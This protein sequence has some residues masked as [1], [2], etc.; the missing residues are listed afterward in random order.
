M[1]RIW[2]QA[3]YGP[4]GL[5][6]C[7]DRSLQAVKVVAGDWDE[8]SSLEVSVLVLQNGV[9]E[10]LHQSGGLLIVT[11]GANDVV[12]GEDEWVSTSGVGTEESLGVNN[13]VVLGAGLLE[14]QVVECNADGLVGELYRAVAEVDLG[15][16]NA[17]AFLLVCVAS[18]NVG[19]CTLDGSNL[20]SNTGGAVCALTDSVWELLAL[21]VPV[22]G[23][24]L[25]ELLEVVR[26]TR[27]V[28]TEDD[29]DVGVR[30][31][32]SLVGSL[33]LFVVPLGD[34]ALE[35][36]CQ[37]LG[38]QVD[39]GVTQVI[40]DSNWADGGWQ[41]PCVVAL[42]TLLAASTSP[43][44]SFRAESEPAKSTVPLVKASTPAP[45]PEEV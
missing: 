37:G 27:L 15:N 23:S 36:L 45:E 40:S 38:L 30:K 41:V 29:G 17:V 26:G 11:S 28:R 14:C 19:D 12:G 16:L 22:T 21:V 8:A 6:D 13:H 39:L 35:D 34:L 1:E 43:L 20:V 9:H 32:G 3:V 24:G 31:L 44:S 42:A 5:L 33:N 25:Q 18:L 10:G 7:F 4:R 2:G